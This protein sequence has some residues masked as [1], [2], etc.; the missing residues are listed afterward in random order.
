MPDG[1]LLVMSA[2]DIGAEASGMLRAQLDAVTELTSTPGL[3]ASGEKNWISPRSSNGSSLARLESIM[4]HI[5]L[6]ACSV[7]LRA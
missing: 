3:A 5:S 2:R 1:C 6:S 4:A 7:T